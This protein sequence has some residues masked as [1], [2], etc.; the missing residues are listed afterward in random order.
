[1][2]DLPLHKP[3]FIT[4]NLALLSSMEI[5]VDPRPFSII[6]LPLKSIPLTTIDL[7]IW[8]I[9][10][11]DQEVSLVLPSTD[12]NHTYAELPDAK[13]SFPWSLLTFDM[14]LDHSIIGFLATI[15][16]ILAENSIS[17]MAFS[18]F[19]RDHIL[20]QTKHLETAL[21]VLTAQINK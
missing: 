17:I 9:I 21:S 19:H 15:S 18:A 6:S 1:M 10:R 11:D 5:Q 13:V 4:K 12:S 14:V 20:I 3:P 16:T 2:T 8:C 7:N